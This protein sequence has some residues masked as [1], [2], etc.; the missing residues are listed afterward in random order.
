VT[1]TTHTR[2]HP[3]E[4]VAT[5]RTIEG[6]AFYFDRASRV[7]DNGREFYLEA[8][9]PTTADKNLHERAGRPFPLGYL[10][11]WDPQSPTR[12]THAEPLG[13]VHFTRNDA[14]GR[15][16]FAAPLSKTRAA[17]DMLELVND[18]AV[19]DTS[20]SFRAFK[21]EVRRGI[22][23]RTE[24]ALRELSLAPPGMGQHDGAQVLAVRAGLE[25]A[26]T[27]RLDA[28]RRRKALLTRP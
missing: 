14:L 22:T 20:V 23:Y 7:T 24:I 26:G 25:L 21:S 9:T 2:T 11:P 3:A 19:G 10:H 12:T 1:T 5:G 17:D 6:V 18:G 15:M 8:F 16:E 13:V 28:L 27:P 4:I